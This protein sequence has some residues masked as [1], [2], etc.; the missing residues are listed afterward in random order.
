MDRVLILVV[1]GCAL[2]FFAVREGS[3]MTKSRVYE[4]I[5]AVYTL[6]C[7]FARLYLPYVNAGS[8]ES[9]G[10]SF[11]PV[12]G[13]W[14][15][16]IMSF[17]LLWI[18]AVEKSWR[19]RRPKLMLMAIF[20]IYAAYTLVN[21]FSVSRIHTLIEVIYLSSF[22][23]FIYMFANCFSVKTVVRGIYMGLA[24]RVGAVG[25]MGHPN[26]LGTYASYYFTFF[27]ACFITN[28]RRRESAILAGLAL[29]VIVLSA[30]RSA[31]AASF[32]AL[33]AVVVFYVYRRYKLISF[34][35][36]LKG[37]VPVGI[38]V[39]LLLSGP[40][41]F[42]F[43]DVENLDEMTTSRLMHYYCGYEIF[44][45]HPLVGV[46][47]NN[48][49]FYLTEN[50]SAP[51]VPNPGNGS[52]GA[53]H[54]PRDL[55]DGV[56]VVLPRPVGHARLV[57]AQPVRPR[58]GGRVRGPGSLPP[59]GEKRGPR[60]CR[61][62]REPLPAAVALEHGERGPVHPPRVPPLPAHSAPRLR[63]STSS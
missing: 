1:L 34:Q 20:L 48:H 43:S 33:V 30:S 57:V 60:L 3:R 50:T 32:M 15:F 24:A 19:I 28:F 39:A 45:D 62:E 11:G 35:S 25:T 31:L 56:A 59:H 2:L 8:E 29:I 63:L 38:L 27:V 36:F 47:M 21:P 14:P 10:G 9:L 26:V 53:V 4:I 6:S 12:G 42:L 18:I 22:A 52:L 5:I 23:I 44:M 37:I 16:Y 49:L 13:I 17:L 46:S 55:V 54:D 40:L 61:R 7:C 58:V 41:N 51:G